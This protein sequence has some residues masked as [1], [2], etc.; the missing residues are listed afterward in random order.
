[1]SGVSVTTCSIYVAHVALGW[2]GII[3]I[4]PQQKTYREGSKCFF[5]RW[6]SKHFGGSL[7][8]EGSFRESW[9]REKL[10]AVFRWVDSAR[11]CI[12][13]FT[14]WWWRAISQ[15]VLAALFL[16][17]GSSRGSCV[18]GSFWN[19]AATW[20][21]ALAIHRR[22]GSV[23]ATTPGPMPQHKHAGGSLRRERAS[24]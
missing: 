12:E 24:R 1:M 9:V 17:E 4:P 19:A 2:I 13:G 21:L 18:G 10:V 20:G 14:R 7:R 6:M 16:R 5:L 22:N 23:L 8:R 15:S 11:R 3:H